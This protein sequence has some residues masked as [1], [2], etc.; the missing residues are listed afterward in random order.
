MTENGFWQSLRKKLIPRIYALKLNLRFAA[1]IPDCW[2]SG[3]E[4]DL[5]LELKYMKTV[6]PSIDPTKL[7][8]ALQQLW[9]ISRHQ[10]GRRVAVLIG[11]PDGHFIFHGLSW[12]QPISRGTFTMTAKKTAEIAHDL[13]DYLGELELK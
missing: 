5:W 10:E 11:S 8:S 3:Q 2:L 9:L 12:Q 1:G 13:V 4:R 6:P 7:L